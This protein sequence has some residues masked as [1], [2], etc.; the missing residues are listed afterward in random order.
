M[1]KGIKQ[2]IEGSQ[3]VSA[4]CGLGASLRM[5]WLGHLSWSFLLNLPLLQTK[6]LQYPAQRVKASLLA[7]WW[8]SE[9]A[10]LGVSA[11]G[12]LTSLNRTVFI[13]GPLPQLCREPLSLDSLWF[14]LQSKPPVPATA[15]N[16][17]SPSCGTKGRCSG[18]LSS[19]TDFNQTPPSVASLSTS[20]PRALI[21]PVFQFC[22]VKS[23]W[24]PATCWLR[25]LLGY[26]L[27]DL[28]SNFPTFVTIAFPIVLLI[29]VGLHFKETLQCHSTGVLEGH[30]SWR[31]SEP[32]CS[33]GSCPVI[34]EK[35]KMIFYLWPVSTTCHSTTG[36]I[37]LFQV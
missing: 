23:G 15:G 35:S 22:G 14:P 10:G 21:L 6:I 19:S 27:L 17:E 7:F 26:W 3:P 29:L 30:E 12:A 24:L 20:F 1:D 31:E 16:E 28:F 34:S 11:L 32:P 9:T 25:V 2:L 33:L 36:P 4:R 8:Q 5:I 37:L 13:M 18:D